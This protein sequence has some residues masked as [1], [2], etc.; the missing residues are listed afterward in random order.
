M[1]AVIATN[2]TAQT[3]RVVSPGSKAGSFT[4][5]VLA[6]SKDLSSEY[7]VETIAPGNFCEAIMQLDSTTPTLFFWAQDYEAALRQNKCPSAK[8]KLD[9][10]N[11]IRFNTDSSLVCSMKYTKDDFLKSNSSGNVGHT[12][13]AKLFSPVI[14]NINTALGTKHKSIPYSGNGLVRLALI[15]GEVDYAMVTN[16]HANFIK[17]NKGNCFLLLDQ[18]SN[19]YKG[20]ASLQALLPKFAVTQSFDTAVFALNMTAAQRKQ[21]VTTMKKAH[22][23]CK[24]AIGTYTKCDTLLDLNWDITPADYARFEADTKLLLVD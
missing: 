2:A 17:E 18:P 1:V 21:L 3:L 15:N 4:M 16:E 9:F 19:Q 6:Y 14:T 5:Q 8:V 22:A 10:S 12:T 20:V 13:P 23:D 11:I 24:S 7:T